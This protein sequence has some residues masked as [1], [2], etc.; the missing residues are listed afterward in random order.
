MQSIRRLYVAKKGVFADEA[1]RMLA[2]LQENLLIKGLTDIN[3]FHRY[4]VAGLDD[5]AFEAAKTMIFSEPP[6]D[7]VYDELPVKEGDTVLA[8][9]YLPG[10][11]DQRADSA[12]QCL[13]MLTM[14]NDSLV[15]TARVVVLSGDLSD[16]DVAA[17]KHYCINPVEA[18]E[19]SLDPVDT[20]EMAWEQPADVAVI[21]GFTTMDDAALKELSAH[22]GLA[23]SFDDLKFCQTYFGEEE[24]RNPTVT[25]IRVIDTYWSDHCRH[26]TFMTEL[27]DVAFEDGKFTAPIQRATKRIKQRGKT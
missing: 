26:T 4:D 25:E 17:I 24:K 3:I 23:M 19:A 6:V 8:I 20:L 14:Q 16:E 12:M 22:M 2:D 18:R 11:Y 13:Q 7:A 5:A 15:R 21:E 27:T 1:K 9:E 10:Q